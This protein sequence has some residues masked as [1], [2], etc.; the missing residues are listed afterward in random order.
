MVRKLL[1]SQADGYAMVTSGAS[2]HSLADV[3]I[4]SAPDSVTLP[5]NVLMANGKWLRIRLIVGTC[6][7]VDNNAS[8]G[9]KEFGEEMLARET[10]LEEY[11]PRDTALLPHIPVLIFRHANIVWSN[12]LVAQWGKTSKVPFP[13]LAGHWTAMEN[14][15]PWDPTFPAGYTLLPKAAYGFSV[16]NCLTQGPAYPAR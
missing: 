5:R 8:D 9:L 1:R 11:T 12:W 3:E 14:Q 16:S 15:V 10:D 2:A 7:G 4:L 13:D 6:F